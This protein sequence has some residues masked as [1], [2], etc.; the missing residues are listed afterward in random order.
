MVQAQGEISAAK[1]KQMRDVI[2]YI[3]TNQVEKIFRIIGA[4][5]GLHIDAPIAT[6]GGMT[7][8][9]HSAA[10]SGN[11][12]ATALM[13]KGPNVSLR[14]STGRNALHYACRAGNHKTVKLLLNVMSPEDREQATNGGITPL[15]A[16]VQSG[17]IT[18]V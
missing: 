3:D 5:D 9:M 18:V 4:N 1:Q 16:A 10:V 8:L 11:T 14:D 13:E 6:I 2:R 7:S 17:D 12:V 15:M